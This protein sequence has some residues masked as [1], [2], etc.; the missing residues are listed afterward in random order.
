MNG[1][2]CLLD[3]CIDVWVKN[4]PDAEAFRFNDRALS[5]AE[6][7]RQSDQMAR[8]LFAIGVRRGDRVGIL[9][10]RCI[11]MPVAVYGVLKAGAAY[12]PL[13]P[14]APAVRLAQTAAD[15]GLEVIISHDILHDLMA[16]IAAA[17]P[18][19]RVAAGISKPIGGGVDHLS[20]DW[21]LNL[22]QGPAADQGR[23]ADDPCYII[24]TSGSTGVPKGMVH[25]HASALAYARMSAELYGLG[26]SDRMANQSPLHFDMSKFEFFA[27]PSR[28]ACTILIPEAYARLPAS[29]TQ[30]LQDERIT[31]LYVV[32]FLLIQILQSGVIDQRDLAAL[33]WV[34][35]G[36]EPISAGCVAALQRALP[37]ARFSNSYG[38]AEVNQV[39]YYHYPAQPIAEDAPIPIGHPCAGTS[40]R[41][42]NPESGKGELL[43]AAPT[44]MRGYWRQ[45][46]LGPDLDARHF[47]DLPDQANQ[48]R[49][50]Y[51]TGDIVWQDAA[52]L[53]YFSG[54]A[55]RQIKVRGVRVEL[56]EVELALESHPLVSEAATIL[57]ENGSVL[58][59]F[60]VLIPGA[61]LIEAALIDHLSKRLPPHSRPSTISV[62]PTFPRTTTDKIDRKALGK[63]PRT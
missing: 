10:R 9:Q 31:T 41:I 56:D 32:P 24:F 16:G 59:S 26:P 27:G 35:H 11:E 37:K 44:M 18:S 45:P 12:V 2:A 25:T 29:F 7:D 13:D 61:S 30:L 62:L 4:T 60:V 55:D 48:Q 1:A 53:Y 57:A 15:C 28:G 36:G 8:G 33:R 21:L 34:I 5:Y 38:P 63:L 23:Q 50:Y 22:D 43:V 51:K 6:L 49:R 3:E 52:G 54:R 19:L 40:L 20:F 39:T 14:A 17:V 58:A 47:V 46:D 42:D